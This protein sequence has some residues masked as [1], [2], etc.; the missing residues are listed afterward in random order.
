MTQYFVQRYS[1]PSQ[2]AAATTL[3]I[4]GATDQFDTESFFDVIET[5]TKG[6][7][8]PDGVIVIVR[9]TIMQAVKERIL[10]DPTI[11][12]R[13]GSET[14]LILK[15]YGIN[16]TITREEN[17]A[18][19]PLSQAFDLN[20]FKRV[21]ITSIAKSKKA[22]VHATEHY[23]FENPSKRHSTQ[24]LRLANILTDG[25]EI[26][27]IAFCCLPYLHNEPAK[28]Y[29]DTPAL[30]SLI[31]SLQEQLRSFE[32]L[33]LLEPINFESYFNL[34]GFDFKFQDESIVLIS[35]STTGGLAARLIDENKFKSKQVTQ[36]IYLGSGS[37][38]YQAICELAKDKTNPEGFASIH[39]V[40]ADTCEPCKKHSVPIPI[41]GDQFT[42]A[43]PQLA[44]IT[45][46]EDHQRKELKD[47]LSC[48]LGTG[49]FQ[50]GL[51]DSVQQLGDH[52]H[53]ICLASLLK[54]K[55][56]LKKLDYILDRSF[57]AKA[58]KIV[59]A[60]KDSRELAKH[61]A[62][63]MELPEAAS[64]IGIDQI[65]EIFR[66]N[67][68]PIV[69]VADAV[70]SG[71]SLQDISRRLRDYS[72]SVPIIY[73]V[74]ISKTSGEPSRE[75]L[76][77]TLSF[78]EGPSSHSFESIFTI[79]LPP[80]SDS[81]AWL[82]ERNLLQSI[83]FRSMREQA[84]AG[85]FDR[86]LKLLNQSSPLKEKLFIPSAVDASLGLK[87]GFAFWKGL[88]HEGK[89]EADVYFTISS[90]LQNVRALG[91]SAAPSSI[92]MIRSNWLQQTV[93]DPINFDRYNDGMI[94]ASLLRAAHPRELNYSSSPQLSQKAFEII[95]CSILDS[96]HEI[97][98]ASAEF[99]LA[100]ATRRLNL[101]PA[102]MKKLREIDTSLLSPI[103]R[104]LLKYCQ[105]V[106]V[107]IV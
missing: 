76:R 3:V 49:A 8:V 61:I 26:A 104:T 41:Q 64:L 19:Q 43:G 56:F 69:V 24:F 32:P 96:M 52:Q 72:K 33:R 101:R 31:F 54:S 45:I 70:E 21:A 106:E 14:P 78:A 103:L 93:I 9:S 90:V 6:V 17:L 48:S 12:E 62:A 97:G 85:F 71:R 105:S 39:T 91:L 50:V 73:L 55:N 18:T 10:G 99:L 58:N 92:P 63:R 79:Y 65:G 44:P 7:L 5:N 60:T 23:H 89:S 75:I 81:H 37:S 27:F 34:E 87:P 35:A 42:F 57:P 67:N 83:D 98:T 53:F 100:V 4:F 20:Q 66:D 59:C 95:E 80:S 107:K 2:E 30:Y 28:V 88:D 84:A 94:Q 25:A 68:R 40:S 47:F 13:L 16:G 38:R 29:I 11:R 15:G 86:R 36:L 22:V 102:E 1:A 74:G 46:I 82:D 51:G 77:K